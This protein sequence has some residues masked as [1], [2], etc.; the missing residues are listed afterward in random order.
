MGDLDFYYG[1][2]FYF[3]FIEV[4]L[5]EGE[6]RFVEWGWNNRKVMIFFF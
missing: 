6:G 4:Y 5:D 3:V 2:F 1:W